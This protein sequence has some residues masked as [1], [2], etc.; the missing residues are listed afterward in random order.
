MGN[1]LEG[2]KPVIEYFHSNIGEYNYSMYIYPNGHICSE[3]GDS[4]Y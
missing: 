2:V 1:E 4:I 3:S